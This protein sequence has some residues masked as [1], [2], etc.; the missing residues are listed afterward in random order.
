MIGCGLIAQAHGLAA[1]QIPERLR[2]S[3]CVSRRRAS[4]EAW[5]QVM[6]IGSAHVYDDLDAMLRHEPLDGVV[7]ATWPADHRV[8]VE[9]CLDHGLRYVLCEKALVTRP[10]DALAIWERARA[11]GAI[12]VEGFMYRH[13]PAMVRLRERVMSGELGPVD[14][15][16]ATFHMPAQA[17]ARSERRSWREQAD[18]GGGVP[19]D[20]LCYPVDAAGWIAGGIPERALACGQPNPQTG[21]IDRLYGVIEYSSGCVASVA[22]SRRAVFDQCLEVTCEHAQV[23]LPV[24]WTIVGDTE[25]TEARS[26][27][28]IV[29]RESHIAVPSSSSSER[30]IDLP[31]FRLQL[32]NFAGVIRAEAEPA[33]SLRESVINAFVIDALVES[34]HVGR[35]IPIRIPPEVGSMT[36]STRKTPG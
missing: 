24:A 14:N 4:A 27:R 13:H 20:F 18:A 17:P 21:T 23:R 15:I 19:H 5:A 33:V 11:L 30:L 31:V 36:S 12:V 25:I 6:D 34:M 1:L 2:F 28:F 3:A 32:E 29:R 7:I 10:A 26:P 9:T 22:S 8:H 35:S 16:H